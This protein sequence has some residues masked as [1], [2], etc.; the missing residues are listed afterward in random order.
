MRGIFATIAVLVVGIGISLGGTFL[1]T[2]KGV[3]Y[4]EKGDYDN[5]KKVFEKTARADSANPI[6]HLNLG[7]VY[8][9]Q[10]KYPEAVLEYSRGIN[11]DTAAKNFDRS[12]ISQILYN[13]GNAFVQM[14][15]LK[16]AE[17][18]YKNALVFNPEDMDAKY[19]LELVLRKQMQSQSSCQ[20]KQ[21]KQQQNKQNRQNQQNKQN[22]QNQ[23]NQQNQQ[24]QNQQQKQKQQQKQQQNQQQNQQKQQKPKSSMTPEQAKRLMEAMERQE[25][26]ELSNWLK[27]KQ[28]QQRRGSPYE[29]PNDW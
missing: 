25:Q 27:Q 17:Q 26:E 3:K 11:S 6:T 14:D 10:G 23:K 7:D 15:S 5:A 19:N 13:I 20:N 9:R 21:Q 22:Q 1:D 8:Y 28:K 12:V 29:N 4:F 2:W 16:Q 18:F 24:N